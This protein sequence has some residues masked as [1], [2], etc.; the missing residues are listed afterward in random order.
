[1]TDEPGLHG[2]DLAAADFRA[3]RADAASLVH[4]VAAKFES[5]LPGHC[6]VGRRRT[7][8]SRKP[9]VEWVAVDLGDRLFHLSHV[10]EHLVAE[11]EEG[12]HDM[13][14]RKERVDLAG[15][16]AELKAELERQAVTHAD[17]RAALEQLLS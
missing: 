2:I 4:L 10:D 11:I 1:M 16:L 5:A 17:A 15:W 14:R 12:V 8:R 6:R 3:D 13:R 7:L 9:S